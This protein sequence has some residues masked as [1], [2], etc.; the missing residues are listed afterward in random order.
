MS[1]LHKDPYTFLPPTGNGT[2][3]C[4]EEIHVVDDWYISNL[5]VVLCSMVV[6]VSFSI[7][8]YQSRNAGPKVWKSPW[9]FI[10]FG[11]VLMQCAAILMFGY[12]IYFAKHE[13][14]PTWKSKMTSLL[15]CTDLWA[16][17]WIVGQYLVISPMV[18]MGCIKWKGLVKALNYIISIV[19]FAIMLY[20][21]FW[22]KNPGFRNPTLQ[23]IVDVTHGL[24]L[25]GNLMTIVEVVIKRWCFSK[26]GMCIAITTIL[27]VVALDLRFNKN[28]H[29]NDSVMECIW[30]LFEGASLILIWKFFISTR[31]LLEPTENDY[32]VNG[33]SR[34][35]LQAI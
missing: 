21:E 4:G 35:L 34:D 13:N 27:N 24:V 1:L 3:L 19:M 6:V 5:G 12:F 16:G 29:I 32:S 15:G 22:A 20:F 30:Y 23:R 33:A 18:D 28:S 17:Y 14:P 7:F 8:W 9:I 11:Y 25:V 31:D 10:F 2:F 26:Q